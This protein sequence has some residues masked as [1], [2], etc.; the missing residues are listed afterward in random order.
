MTIDDVLTRLRRECE[1]AGSR[2]EWAR[3]N[4]VSVTYVSDVLARR[5]EPGEG[6]LRGL[7]LER[8]VTYRPVRRSR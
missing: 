8:V 1:A 3:R 7:R 5:R 6:I 2:S 4:G